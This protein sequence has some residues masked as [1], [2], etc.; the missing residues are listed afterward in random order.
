MT[1]P[2]S[3][4]VVLGTGGTIAGRGP[5]GGSGVDYRAGDI[6]VDA[7]VA[8]ISSLPPAGF[9][10]EAEQV[11]QLDSK[12]MDAATWRRLAARV[13]HHA[14]RDAVRGI[15]V[16]HGTDTLEETAWWLARTSATAKPIAVTGAMRPSTARSAD[17]PQNLADALAVAAHEGASG[18]VA[19]FAGVV[20]AAGDVRKLH[21]YRVDA[22]GS[23]DAGPVGFV[24]EGRVRRLRD[25][26]VVPAIGATTRLHD[27]AAWPWVE[28]VASS[29]SADARG[30]AALVDAG[31]D[32]LVVATTGNGQVHVALEGALRDAQGRGVAVLRCLRAGMGGT[33][34]AG[35]DAA[36]AFAS[37]GALG[38]A[39]AR[40]E[41]IVRL[42][43][44][45]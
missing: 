9:A 21:P 38:P 22:F 41:L 17:G 43:A 37:A 29:A 14:A 20:H 3:I 2:R 44:A 11:A 27:A 35:T 15:V 28:I 12:D 25:W 6:G 1:Q 10:V 30:V 18:V 13:A 39:A 36:V 19:V 40:V 24:E 26:P 34:V 31:V 33:I 45:A 7:L 42:L 16:A 32:G 4:L 23:G 8:G 5:A